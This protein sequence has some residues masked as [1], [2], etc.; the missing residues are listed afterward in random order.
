[1]KPTINDNNKKVELKVSSD[2]AFQRV[3]LCVA[4]PEWSHE[5]SWIF[6]TFVDGKL[7]AQ[8]NRDHFRNRET[9]TE[10]DLVIRSGAKGDIV[11]SAI[12][13]KNKMTEL[14]L[15]F[16]GEELSK[17]QMIYAQCSKMIEYAQMRGNRLRNRKNEIAEKQNKTLVF[18][19]HKDVIKIHKEL[20]TAFES[21]R[22]EYVKSW[23]KSKTETCEFW[24]KSAKEKGSLWKHMVSGY[25]T[26]SQYEAQVNAFNRASKMFQMINGSLTTNLLPN[27]KALCKENAKREVEE[28]VELYVAN[29]TQKIGGVIV[30][31]NNLKTAKNLYTGLDVKG[32]QGDFELSFKDD[33]KFTIH[34]MAVFAEGEIQTAHYRF[35]ITFHNVTFPNGNLKKKMSEEEMLQQF[36]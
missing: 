2:S 21:K 15:D 34:S 30:N 22:L 35:P 5:G 27:Y 12:D 19:N 4:P 23:A 8:M 6:W 36:K 33:S 13:L 17:L 1:M 7:A 14:M 3:T 25:R 24:Q 11:V 18:L 20:R 28:L 31:K 26:K 32:F 16:H 10:D 29:I 9:A